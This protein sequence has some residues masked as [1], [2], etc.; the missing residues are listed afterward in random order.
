VLADGVRR[1][2]AASAV[3]PGDPIEIAQQIW[4]ARHGATSLELRGIGFVDDRDAY[5]RALIDT[6]L[7]GLAPVS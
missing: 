1:A 6:V 7:A 3:R 5:Y 2:Q 4:A